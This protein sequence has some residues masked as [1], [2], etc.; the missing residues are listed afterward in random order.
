[1]KE[2]FVL[3]LVIPLALLCFINL[4]FAQESG[5]DKLKTE[6]KKTGKGVEVT[7]FDIRVIKELDPDNRVP[8]FRMGSCPPG[9]V[10][11][12]MKLQGSRGQDAIAI[13]I[14]LKFPEGYEGPD[15]SMPV[16]VDAADKKYVSKNMFQPPSGMAQKLQKTGDQIKCEIPVEVPKG[17]SLN[18]LQY[19]DAVFDI[20]DRLTRNN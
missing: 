18:K 12:G 11:P 9:V 20:K 13:L 16:L 19:D 2:K 7:L 10:L 3:K 14:G 6:T 15:F 1:M 5:G 4:A 8:L 17:T